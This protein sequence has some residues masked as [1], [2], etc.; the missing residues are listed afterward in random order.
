[1]R[2]ADSFDMTAVAKRTAVVQA[3]LFDDFVH[4]IDELGPAIPTR[5][6]VAGGCGLRSDVRLEFDVNAAALRVVPRPSLSQ[7][8]EILFCR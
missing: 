1:V 6:N 2:A 3:S 7:V 5:L 8:G 4:V